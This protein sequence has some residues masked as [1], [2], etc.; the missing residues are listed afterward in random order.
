MRAPA[1]SAALLLALSVTVLPSRVHAQAERPPLPA[2]QAELPL[3]GMAR[4]PA[5][6]RETVPVPIRHLSVSRSH[7][8][9]GLLI[10]GLV[11]SAATAA[12]LILYCNDPDT[13]CRAGE[14]A[15]AS[16]VI[17][18]P[19]AAVGALIGSLVRTEE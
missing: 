15:T 19:A 10:G 4:R 1:V 17:V 14:V 13:R 18:L 5:M 3:G 6:Q 11:G 12:L 2:W 9:T 8:K 7:T 16:M